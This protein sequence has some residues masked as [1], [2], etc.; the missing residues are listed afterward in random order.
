M[1]GTKIETQTKTSTPNYI[2]LQ[3]ERISKVVRCSDA[4]VKKEKNKIIYKVIENPVHITATPLDVSNY[5]YLTFQATLL[6]K[7]LIFT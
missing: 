4:K 5:T 1:R 7:L 6:S 3:T 2:K